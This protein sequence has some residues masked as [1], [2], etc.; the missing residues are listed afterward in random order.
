MSVEKTNTN[1]PE[2]KEQEILNCEELEN[3]EGGVGVEVEQASFLRQG[4]SHCCNGTVE[5]IKTKDA[6]IGTL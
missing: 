1:L 3:L 4:V 2:Q 6:T 5:D